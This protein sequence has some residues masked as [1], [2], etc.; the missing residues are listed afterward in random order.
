MGGGRDTK[1]EAGRGFG[2]S[3][4]GRPLFSA[5]RCSAGG[6]A[7]CGRLP[8]SSRVSGAPR[9]FP[10]TEGGRQGG[11]GWRAEGAARPQGAL[12]HSWPR[13][14]PTHRAPAFRDR[15][16]A[17]GRQAG[18]AFRRRWRRRPGAARGDAAD[19]VLPAA[20][21]L[22]ADLL[23]AGGRRLRAAEL[24][25]PLRARV[26]HPRRGEPGGWRWGRA[27]VAGGPR[28]PREGR[29]AP[30]LLARPPALCPR[31][32][33]PRGARSLP[34]G[35]GVVARPSGA[36][37]LRRAGRCPGPGESL[38]EGGHG[39]APLPPPGV[40]CGAVASE[41]R[42]SSPPPPTHAPGT[43]KSEPHRRAARLSGSAEGRGPRSPGGAAL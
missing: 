27:A 11:I 43:G 7:A 12:L 15:R 22:R 30:W 28:G 25:R 1:C 14:A 32:A 20:G 18:A 17:A 24:P 16:I 5:A 8:Q 36:S 13:E 39:A 35:A 42:P 31:G 6:G 2:A 19:G 41:W 21:P 37:S 9:G 29:G 23:A 34:T 10:A 40:G 33:L 38:A 3:G 4:A 26:R